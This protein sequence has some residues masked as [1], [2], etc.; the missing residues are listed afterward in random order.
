M[1]V[2]RSRLLNTAR[3][4]LQVLSILGYIIILIQFKIQVF[5]QSKYFEIQNISEIYDE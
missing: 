4:Y 1:E 3:P 2:T 5:A